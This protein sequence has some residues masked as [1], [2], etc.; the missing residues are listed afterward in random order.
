MAT[1]TL[2]CCGCKDR[3]PRDQMI[4]LPG[5]NFHSGD[6]AS[7]YAMAKV[8]RSN[9]AKLARMKREEKK[10]HKRQKDAIKSRSDWLK[11]AQ[12]AFNAYI[13]LRDRVEPCV[14]CD[15]HHQGQYHAGHYL[16]VGSHPELRFNEDNV[17]KQASYCNQHKSGNQAQYRIRLIAKIG[18][19]RVEALEG[20]HD[21]A[22]WTVDDIKEIKRVYKQKIKEAGT[23]V[24]N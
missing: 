7:S 14:C 8:R 23:K 19:D 18:I 3:Y 21:A 5:G 20:P 13:R 15:R 16:S 24:C 4:K 9:A 12:A 6:C 1:A 10:E 17:H 2:K 22:N 11:E